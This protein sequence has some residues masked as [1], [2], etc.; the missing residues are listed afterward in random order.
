MLLERTSFVFGAQIHY[1]IANQNEEIYLVR[2]CVVV[3]SFIGVSSGPIVYAAMNGTIA[4][5][6]VIISNESVKEIC[7]AANGGKLISL[8]IRD[9]EVEE[10]SFS[11]ILKAVGACK[12]ILQL[13]LCV[14]MVTSN[15]QLSTLCRG[16]Q[17][18]KSLLALL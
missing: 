1:I 11:A 9:C 13:S 17:K 4:L 10:G 7:D 18:N 3:I 2:N 8:S 15:K 5:S 14:G 12:S 6:H 16:L